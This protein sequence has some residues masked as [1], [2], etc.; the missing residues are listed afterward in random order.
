MAFIK[1]VV[2]IMVLIS[3][4]TELII[5]KKYEVAFS[6]NSIL[7]FYHTRTYYIK[8]TVKLNAPCAPITNDCSISAVLDGP[9]I[10][11]P[12]SVS[13]DDNF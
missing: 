2:L 8:N 3:Q 11:T 4:N 12:K 10:N 5:S 7:R 6:T 13:S 1:T 9:D